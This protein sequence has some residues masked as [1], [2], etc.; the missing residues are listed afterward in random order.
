MNANLTPEQVKL[1]Q[2]L[3]K[4]KIQQRESQKKYRESKSNYKDIQ[5]T[6]NETRK[7]KINELKKALAP[8]EP[9]YIHINEVIFEPPKIDKRNRRGTKKGFIT[10]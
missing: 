10:N 8:P 4:Q 1:L 5:K 7:R 9:K 6:Y 2:Q 3:Q